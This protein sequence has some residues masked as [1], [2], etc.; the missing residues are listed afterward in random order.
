M[1]ASLRNQIITAMDEQARLMGWAD[2]SADINAN[3]FDGAIYPVL[4]KAIENGNLMLSRN[5]KQIIPVPTAIKNWLVGVISL[6]KQVE[7]RQHTVS[8]RQLLNLFHAL[9]EQAQRAYEDAYGGETK[10]EVSV[11]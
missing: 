6:A 5:T 1:S 9:E 3:M 8:K 2:R 4:E 10:Q 11:R 7:E